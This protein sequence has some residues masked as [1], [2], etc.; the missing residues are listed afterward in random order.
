MWQLRYIATWGC[1]LSCQSFF[2]LITRPM[3]QPISQWFRNLRGHLHV[4][5]K[6]QH[7]RATHSWVIDD[8]ANFS[9]QGYFGNLRFWQTLYNACS[10]TAIFELPIKILTPPLD[11]VTWLRIPCMYATTITA[12]LCAAQPALSQLRPGKGQHTI[13]VANTVTNAH[14]DRGVSCR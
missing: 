6:F 1:Q 5:M 12:L 8:L 13:I 7:N 3:Y 2:A 9:W 11:S 10:E 4:R 14:W